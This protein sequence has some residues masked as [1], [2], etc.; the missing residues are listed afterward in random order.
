MDPFLLIDQAVDAYQS[1]RA[2]HRAALN[3]GSPARV[4]DAMRELRRASR[5]LHTIMEATTL[6]RET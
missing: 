2:H 5:D 3:Q 1:A 4:I 6:S